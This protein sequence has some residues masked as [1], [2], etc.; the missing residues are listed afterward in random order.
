MLL[1]TPGLSTGDWTLVH[2]GDKDALADLGL[3]LTYRAR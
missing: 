3:I 1:R 2:E